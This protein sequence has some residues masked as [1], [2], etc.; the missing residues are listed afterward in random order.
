VISYVVPALIDLSPGLGR[1]F[2][3]RA[4]QAIESTV[5]PQG[6]VKTTG[7]IVAAPA[8]MKDMLSGVYSGFKTSY[9]PDKI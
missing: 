9:L 5:K 6:G 4:R 2:P 1:L 8:G 3:Q 7:G